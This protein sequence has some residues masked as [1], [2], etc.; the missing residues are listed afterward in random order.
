[1]RGLRSKLVLLLIVYFSG[2][3]TAIYALSPAPENH[4]Q[5]DG[6]KSMLDSILKSDDFAKSFNSGMRKSIA[7]GREVVDRSTDYIKHKI[8]E[9]YLKSDG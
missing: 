5:K 4:I 2:F 6:Q 3:A 1:M 9:K 8:D 7:L